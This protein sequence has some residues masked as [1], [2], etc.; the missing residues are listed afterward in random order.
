MFIVVYYLVTPQ[1]GPLRVVAQNVMGESGILSNLSPPSNQ[2][3]LMYLF[4]VAKQLKKLLMF[5]RPR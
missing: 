1:F 2:E 4:L 5:V 3:K